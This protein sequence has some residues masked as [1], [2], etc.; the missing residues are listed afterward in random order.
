MD[1]KEVREH[2]D[3]GRLQREYFVDDNNLKQGK[4]LEYFRNGEIMYEPNFKDNLEHG[5]VVIYEKG[6]RVKYRGEH[7]N[8]KRHGVWIFDSK[9]DFYINGKKCE[10]DDLKLYLITQRLGNQ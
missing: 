10:E 3:S 9:K 7:A 1:I 5:T 6:G 2:Y 8:G 4:S